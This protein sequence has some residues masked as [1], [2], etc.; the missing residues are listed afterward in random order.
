MSA[1]NIYTTRYPCQGKEKNKPKALPQAKSSINAEKELHKKDKEKDRKVSEDKKDQQEPPSA[2]PPSPQRPAR[3]E[4]R[5]HPFTANQSCSHKAHWQHNHDTALPPNVSQTTLQTVPPCI[6]CD[7]TFHKEMFNVTVLILEIM[8]INLVLSY[9][10]LHF[11]SFLIY[12]EK[13]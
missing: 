11:L 9:P 8:N 10:V 7:I 5:W 1:Q 4:G 3:T 12:W 6:Q 13:S 2:C